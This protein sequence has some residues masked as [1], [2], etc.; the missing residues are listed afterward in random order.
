MASGAIVAAI[1]GALELASKPPPSVAT[2]DAATSIADAAIAAMH[3][4]STDAG[5]PRSRTIL[6]IGVAQTFGYKDKKAVA[7]ALASR[8][9]DVQSCVRDGDLPQNGVM[10][11]GRAQWVFGG[12]RPSVWQSSSTVWS[13]VPPLQ[14]AL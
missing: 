8:L 4:A 3:T 14:D 5:P 10:S 9:A 7:A 6:S 13:K 2:A 12:V 1:W 11:I